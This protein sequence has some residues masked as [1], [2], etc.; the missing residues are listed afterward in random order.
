MILQDQKQI[1]PFRGIP[2]DSLGQSATSATISGETVQLYYNNSGTL[3]ADAGQAAGTA[4]LGVLAYDYSLDKIASCQGRFG[5]TSLTFTSTALT[6]EVF[7]QPEELEKGDALTWKQRLA[8]F[9]SALSPGQYVVDYRDG[10]IY[11]KKATT[12]STL[13]STSYVIAA[14]ANLIS[15]GNVA[16]GATD[17]GNPVK[18]GGVFNLTPPAYTDG[19]RTN[20]QTDS[21]GNAQTNLATK[22]RG[23][24]DVN[25]VLKVQNQ[26]TY[27]VPLTASAL[28][29]TG[30]GQLF[31]FVVNSCGAGATLKI[32]DNTSAATTV[33]LD[34]M[35]F[36]SAVAQGP[37]VVT[38]P[39]AVKFSVGC[40][41]TI[42]V[43]AMSVTPIWN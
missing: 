39:A 20:F 26:G 22:I 37:V 15:G 4:V 3:T 41:F 30:A 40:Y 10:V 1:S 21:M 23:E 42:A 19:Q 35:T 24:D 31:G 7:I 11:G 27:T 2:S 28:V 36:T 6:T 34:T 14:T 29:K 5:D 43:A 25:D 16:A 33:L 12:A 9:T 18:V 13:T 32:W 38:L 17:S 8:T